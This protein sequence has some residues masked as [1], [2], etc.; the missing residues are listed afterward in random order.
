MD[1]QYRFLALSLVYRDI[2]GFTKSPNYIMQMMKS[3]KSL[4]FNAE[5]HS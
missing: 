2:S 1:V 4:Q 5:K 3:P